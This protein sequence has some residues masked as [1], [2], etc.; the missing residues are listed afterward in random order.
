MQLLGLRYIPTVVVFDSEGQTSQNVGAMKPDAFR[1][2]LR[3]RA[4][5]G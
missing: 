5:G 3:Q 4:L 2:F 1:S